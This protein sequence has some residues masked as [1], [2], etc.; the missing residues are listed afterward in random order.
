MVVKPKGRSLI[1]MKSRGSV[2]ILFI[3]TGLG[4]VGLVWVH[5]NYSVTNGVEEGR[6]FPELP[7]ETLEGKVAAFDIHENKPV[8]AVFLDFKC[9]FCDEQLIALEKLFENL[10]T[11][12]VV[13]PI[14]EKGYLTNDDK[15]KLSSYPFP[16]LVTP[17]KQIRKRLGNFPV[18]AFFFVN[19]KGILTQKYI[20]SLTSEELDSLF[21]SQSE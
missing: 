2:L 3:L 12:V 20:G 14:F 21:F 17:G 7:L 18:P 11:E 6:P 1:H 13:V 9:G 15:S 10:E 16:V 8:L 19:R 5:A 4:T